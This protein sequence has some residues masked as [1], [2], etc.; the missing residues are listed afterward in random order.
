MRIVVYLLSLAVLQTDRFQVR[1]IGP[2]L[3]I[4]PSPGQEV[5]THLILT[6]RLISS[7]EHRAMGAFRFGRNDGHTD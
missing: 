3:Y 1:S 7:Y 6:N 4:R 5:L 2:D